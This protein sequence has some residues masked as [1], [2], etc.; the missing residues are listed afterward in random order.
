MTKAS[1]FSIKPQ[2]TVRTI[3]RFNKAVTSLEKAL[4]LK[5]LPEHAERDA[6]LLRFEFA[7]ELMP[8][9]LARVLAER[10]AAPSLPKDTVRAA[11]TADLVDE[12]SAS[13]LLLVIDDRNRM[14]HDYSEEYA[15]ALLARVKKEYFPVFQKLLAQISIN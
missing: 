11:R 14:V 6:V 9:V 10:G 3:A 5:E 15:V 1:H 8:K 13:V 4:A 2:L 7:A 12:A